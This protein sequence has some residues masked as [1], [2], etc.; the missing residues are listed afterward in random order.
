VCLL[1]V[2]GCPVRDSLCVGAVMVTESGNDGHMKFA[3]Q[4]GGMTSADRVKGSMLAVHACCSYCSAQLF[5]PCAIQEGR[6]AQFMNLA[7][8]GVLMACEGCP[9]RDETR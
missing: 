3:G 6:L 5:E 7:C 9:W 4:T 2:Q 1:A 8:V